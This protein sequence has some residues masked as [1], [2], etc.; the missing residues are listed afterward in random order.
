MKIKIFILFLLCSL[1]IQKSAAQN[2]YQAGEFLK[3][4]VSYM[5]VNAGYATMQLGETR[6]DGKAVYHAKGLGYTSGV[7]KTFFKVHDDYQSYF[8]KDSGKPYKYI[9]NI[10]EGGYK[11][12]I[13]GFFNHSKKSILVKEHIGKTQTSYSITPG[14]QDVVSSFYHFRDHPKI[15]NMKTGETI[16]LDM[17]FDDEIYKFKLK[18]LGKEEIKT[19][20]GKLKAL[21][22]RPYVQSG[23]VFKEEES[24]TM[25]ITDDANYIPLRIQASLLVGSIKADLVEYKGLRNKFGVK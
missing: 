22:F 2:A 7:S 18:F 13:E 6:Y 8:D 5:F 14:I 17:F 24:L 23:R 15:G 4:K 19:K 11:K 20:F 3:F 16:E 10:N 21:K 12:D 9:R 1:S 25:W